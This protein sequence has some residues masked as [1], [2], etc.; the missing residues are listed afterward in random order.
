MLGCENAFSQKAAWPR[1]WLIADRICIPTEAMLL[2]R[3]RGRCVHD[4]LNEL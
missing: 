1:N 3:K 2:A 4:Y